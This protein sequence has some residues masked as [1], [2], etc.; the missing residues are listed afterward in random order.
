MPKSTRT[1]RAKLRDYAMSLP[2]ATA[3]FPWGERVAKVNKKVFAFLGRDMAERLSLGVKL[4]SSHASALTLASAKPMA[5]GLGK[6]GWVSF[7]FEREAPPE[8]AQLEAWIRESYLAIAPKT[9]AAALGVSASGKTKTAKAPRKR[10]GAKT[11]PET[12]RAAKARAK[13]LAKPQS[14]RPRAS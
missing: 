11:P 1:L 5:Y 3:D 9:V 6:S 4:K 14:K 12:P 10:A 8:L 13:A 7:S 2:E